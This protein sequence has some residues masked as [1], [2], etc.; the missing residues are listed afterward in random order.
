M[1]HSRSTHRKPAAACGVA[2]AAASLLLSGCGKR[3]DA[4]MLT[5]PATEVR[6]D[7]GSVVI[8]A[9]SPK[10]QQIKVD[11]VVNANVPFDVVTSPGKIE[12]NPN[13]VSRIVLPLPGR[14]ATVEVKLGDAV[15]RGQ[16][17]VTVECP[18]ADAAESASRQAEA[19]IT[20]ARA[21]LNKA[22]A[23]Y[24]RSNDL[25]QHNAV[26]KKDT[27]TAENALAQAKA[28]LVQ[29]EAAHEQTV[30]RLQLLGLKPGAFGQRV[31]VTAP[32]SGKVLE[33]SIAAGEYRNDTNAPVM[34]VADL[35]SVWVSSDVP[36]S[37]IRLIEPGERIDVNLSA[38]PN[39]TFH[40]RVMR[41]AD[42]VDPQTRTVKVRAQM[43]NS[44]GRFRP[45]MF[46]TIRHTEA[47]RMT[48][49]VPAAAI[50]Q[51][52]GKSVVWME[53]A[54]GHFRPVEVKLGERTGD[55]MPVLAGLRPG[56]RVVVDGAMLLKAQ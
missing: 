46:G 54:P 37:A 4:A 45:E 14:V 11:A 13:L 22:Q 7:D 31:V 24:D 52:D 18:D 2:L 25:F 1:L 44:S 21:N 39:E 17:L 53:Q 28:A 50:V 33:M 43:D 27:L 26:A 19:A 40:A 47:V 15:R 30:R 5:P 41:I 8:A 6:Q 9:A 32:I 48:P 12:A 38:Y 55:R 42:L 10:L 20:T 35:S 23:D 34:T 3:D 51:G 29:A 16:R 49:V 36:E 56:D